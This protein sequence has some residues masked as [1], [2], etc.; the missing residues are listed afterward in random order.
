VTINSLFR[1]HVGSSDGEHVLGK[2]FLTRVL[3]LLEQVRGIKCEVIGSDTPTRHSISASSS[4]FDVLSTLSSALS[5]ASTR[6]EAETFEYVLTKCMD[7]K[8]LGS[9]SLNKDSISE[10]SYRN[11]ALFLIESWLEALNSVDRV[12]GGLL[13]LT[14]NSEKTKPMTLAEKIFAHH[15]LGGCSVEGIK[16]GDVVRVCIDWI[17]ASELTWS[18]SHSFDHK[19][20]QTIINENTDDVQNHGGDRRGE[21]L[22][23]R[24]FVARSRS[25]RRPKGIQ[26]SQSLNLN[27]C[28]GE[29]K[30]GLQDDGVSRCELHHYAHRICA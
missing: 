5:S 10:E 21:N 23:K 14:T 8:S 20:M 29:S 22:T 15:T 18:V 13:T 30:D 7:G 4:I 2:E 19:N 27:P 28:S 6:L 16:P 25:R 11:N 24:S 3:A 26:S 1:I 9:L 12:K 17:I